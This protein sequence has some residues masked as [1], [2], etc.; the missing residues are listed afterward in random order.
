MQAEE[1]VL[2]EA[3]DDKSS[4]PQLTRQASQE[5]EPQQEQGGGGDVSAPSEEEDKGG[6]VEMEEAPHAGDAPAADG[7]EDHGSTN[8][9]GDAPSPPHEKKR[10]N[11]SNAAILDALKKRRKE[12]AAAAS[13]APRIMNMGS[14][15]ERAGGGDPRYRVAVRLEKWGKSHGGGGGGGGGSTFPVFNAM[16]CLGFDGAEEVSIPMSFLPTTSANPECA[17]PVPKFGNKEPIASTKATAFFM[18]KA[19]IVATR[20]LDVAEILK[21]CPKAYRPF[22]LRVQRCLRAASFELGI[23]GSR[24]SLDGAEL[25]IPGVG[26]GGEL[27]LRK[28]QWITA[29]VA[30]GAVLA[31]KLNSNESSDVN[32]AYAATVSGKPVF[33]ADR[34]PI[35]RPRPAPRD[36]GLVTQATGGACTTAARN[37]GGA[38]DPFPTGMVR[39]PVRRP[40]LVAP[41]TAVE[42]DKMCADTEPDHPVYD[43]RGFTFRDVLTRLATNG[44]G[45][46]PDM[47]LLHVLP[48]GETSVADDVR[49]VRLPE[50]EDPK[51]V[52]YG[53]PFVSLG[54]AFTACDVA[55]AHVPWPVVRALTGNRWGPMVSPELMDHVLQCIAERVRFA[56]KGV[57][58]FLKTP[59]LARDPKLRPLG[60]ITLCRRQCTDPEALHHLQALATELAPDTSHVAPVGENVPIVD[61]EICK[62]PPSPSPPFT[63]TELAVRMGFPC[64]P[65][66]HQG[67]LPS[68]EV[69][70]MG[71]IPGWQPAPPGGFARIAPEDVRLATNQR[72]PCGARPLLFKND[73]LAHQA[74][75]QQMNTRLVPV[76][77]PYRSSKTANATVTLVP[78]PGPEGKA[79]LAAFLRRLHDYGR[80][81]LGK[82]EAV[83]FPP[84]PPGDEVDEFVILESMLVEWVRAVVEAYVEGDVAF[85][86]RDWAMRGEF[87]GFTRIHACDEVAKYPTLWYTIRADACPAPPACE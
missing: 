29:H 1:Q 8:G 79:T 24:V 35:A 54:L 33:A 73:A 55:V 52:W 11:G 3:G 44:R 87:M 84:P 77:V 21:V 59:A 48:P 57:D 43:I 51:K 81:T 26:K 45:A 27:R 75:A 16:I 83:A 86:R 53:A 14:G 18:E 74:D 17:V 38:A 2:V 19:P 58:F 15:H 39:L 20:D 70:H 68:S 85:C 46:E 65:R 25:I 23:Y 71:L 61:L 5:A 56:G 50:G 72:E 60:E 10:R 42:Y 34:V 63:P 82:Y 49:T 80:D 64:A 22:V 40:A 28:G 76:F 36:P 66:E 12:A 6:D 4:S 47:F 13:S 32:N 41:A 67:L 31:S 7:P 37:P 62:E 30:P 69:T 78:G 9:N